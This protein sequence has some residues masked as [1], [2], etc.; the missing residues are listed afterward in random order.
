MAKR[1]TA[2]RRTKGGQGTRKRKKTGRRYSL[3]EWFGFGSKKD[4]RWLAFSKKH[5]GNSLLELDTLCALPEPLI[6]IILSEMPGF[7]CQEEEAFERDLAR[8][9]GDGFFLRHPFGYPPTDRPSLAD[10]A[11][12]EGRERVQ[13]WKAADQRIRQMLVE[14]LQQQGRHPLRIQ[15]HF[16]TKKKIQEKIEA[17]K[18]G[19]AGWLVTNPKFQ[20]EWRA[21]RANWEPLIR[22]IGG[23]P[24]YPADFLG[25]SPVVPKPLREFYDSYTQ[26]YQR[27]CI[28]TFVTWDLPIPMW[29]GIATPVFYPLAQVSDAGLS[30]FAPWYLLRDQTFKL[31]DLAKHER[32]AKGPDH[33]QGWFRRDRNKWGHDRQGTMLKVYFY[34]EHCLK[35]RYPDQLNR[36]IDK[37]DHCVSRFLYQKP[38]QGDAPVEK[39]ETIKRIRLELARR[40]KE[41]SESKMSDPTSK[42]SHDEPPR[43]G[44]LTM[45]G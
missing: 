36:H 40:L 16:A 8:A 15:E 35:R 13:R 9:P 28:H 3:A 21:V 7:F 30:L 19:Y 24:T 4:P 38:G 6:D 34:L 26:F 5:P 39:A 37:L 41:C 12:G 44:D 32:F 45:S 18:W 42:E 29:A 10:A 22:E 1:K 31:Q 17:R 11:D 14:D 33:L 20:E 2:T 43:S 23:F 27:W 25:H